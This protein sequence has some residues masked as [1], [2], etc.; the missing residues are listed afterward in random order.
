MFRRIAPV[1]S[2]PPELIVQTAFKGLL[3]PALLFFAHHGKA[4]EP[5]REA[6]FQESVQLS[7]CQGA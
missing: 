1:E 5:R 2:A 3:P 7:L 4:S 6:C